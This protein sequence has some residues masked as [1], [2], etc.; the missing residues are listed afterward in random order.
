[1][2]DVWWMAQA[3][4]FAQTLRTPNVPRLNNYIHWRSSIRDQISHYKPEHVMPLFYLEESENAWKGVEKGCWKMNFWCPETVIIPV[5]PGVGEE[6]HAFCA[7]LVASGQAKQP[8]ATKV[9]LNE[10]IQRF[11]DLYA[12][13]RRSGDIWM[14]DMRWLC[15]TGDA[16]NKMIGWLEYDGFWWSGWNLIMTLRGD[17][18]L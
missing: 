18:I 9:I 16:W 6:L 15:H 2:G 5:H 7:L 10:A 14:I 3:A 8:Q 12:D 1:M 17:R 11:G 4:R 13:G